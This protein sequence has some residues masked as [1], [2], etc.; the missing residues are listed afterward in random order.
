MN[1]NK[2]NKDILNETI[3]MLGK[4]YNDPKPKHIE[5]AIAH[6]KK[7]IKETTELKA[8]HASEIVKEDA[9]SRKL[10][11]PWMDNWL[12]GGLRPQELVLIGAVPH[13]GK[14]HTLV[15]F[16]IQCLFE[17]YKVL[18]VIGVETGN[19]WKQGELD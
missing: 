18:N 14:T 8:I 6:L 17:G 1:E 19:G 3:M 16:G 13:A 12:R 7:S 4:V 9:T 10:G 11:G 15:W 5:L 2:V